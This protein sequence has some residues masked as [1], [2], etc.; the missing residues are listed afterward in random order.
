MTAELVD[1]L[2]ALVSLLTKS[3]LLPIQVKEVTLEVQDEG[4]HGEGSDLDQEVVDVFENDDTEDDQHLVLVCFEL[5]DVQL[6]L[7]VLAVQLD[8]LFSSLEKLDHLRVLLLFRLVE[9]RVIDELNHGLDRLVQSPK[10][11]SLVALSRQVDFGGDVLQKNLFN[12]LYR[13][14]ILIKA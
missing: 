9:G 4:L 7:G 2:D 13:P 12:A 14:N 1:S 10:L 11:L 6:I 8:Q 3:T 5:R